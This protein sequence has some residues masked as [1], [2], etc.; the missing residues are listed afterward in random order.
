MDL[1]T[2]RTGRTGLS[3]SE[4]ALGTARLGNEHDDGTEEVDRETV[5]ALLLDRHA[6]AGGDVV[7]LADVYGGGAAERYVSDWLADR[8][9]ERFV[10]ASKVYW[11]TDPDDP[12]R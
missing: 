11:P 10:L 1:D 8:D 4:L 2:V 12:D 7:D 3:V 5:H 9:R 6:A